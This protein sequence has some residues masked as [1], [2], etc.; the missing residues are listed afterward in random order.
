MSCSFTIAYCT[1]IKMRSIIEGVV[2]KSSEI[3][4]SM[5]IMQ[6]AGYLKHQK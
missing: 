4:F 3:L 6:N 2:E 5:L 1:F